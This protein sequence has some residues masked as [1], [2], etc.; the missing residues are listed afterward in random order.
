MLAQG[1]EEVLDVDIFLCYILDKLNQSDYL[2]NNARRPHGLLDF[3]SG[4]VV[5]WRPLWIQHNILDCKL[6]GLT[7]CVSWK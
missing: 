5:P 7:I 4:F 6:I 3:L 2:L 1:M